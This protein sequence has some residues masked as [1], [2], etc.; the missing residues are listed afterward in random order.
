MSSH[1]WVCSFPG[2]V[3]DFQEAIHWGP[4][5]GLIVSG[6]VGVH[7]VHIHHLHGKV[8]VFF[9]L[10]WGIS[11]CSLLGKI[12]MIFSLILAAPPVWRCG[13]QWVYESVLSCLLSLS[14]FS[15]SPPF[16][17]SLLSWYPLLPFCLFPAVFCLSFPF[18]SSSSLFPL[19][20]LFFPLPPL[21]SHFPPAP[22]KTLEWNVLLSS[23]QGRAQSCSSE[24][25]A[26]EK[27]RMEEGEIEE[28]RK[29][30]NHKC[31]KQLNINQSGTSLRVQWLRLHTSL[32][33]TR[34]QSL[35]GELRS[36]MLSSATKKKKKPKKR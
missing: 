10:P 30:V 1:S 12:V 19:S 31:R 7:V 26:L 28:E 34:V 36:Q 24:F 4:L 16:L 27:E 32:Q 13:E 6:P 14:F 20:T 8:F 29:L 9:F 17:P 21:P 2:T 18:L 23:V 25:A 15:S 5:P 11:C 22:L 35:V 33:G 3:T